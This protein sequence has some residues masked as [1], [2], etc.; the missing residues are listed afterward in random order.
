MNIKT[1]LV[2]TLLLGSLSTGAMAGGHHLTDEQVKKLVVDHYQLMIFGLD[3][4]DDFYKIRHHIKMEG[5]FDMGY[6]NL[7]AKLED[8]Y[9]FRAYGDHAALLD[10]MEDFDKNQ[11]ATILSD[12]ILLLKN[13]DFDLY[14]KMKDFGL[15][16]YIVSG[17]LTYDVDGLRVKDRNHIYQ[18]TEMLGINNEYGCQDTLSELYMSPLNPLEIKDKLDGDI[19]DSDVKK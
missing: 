11:L 8:E 15:F 14:N 5:N 10:R 18:I 17:D 2:S 16:D 7:M 19:C 6:V 1:I 12:H 3:H 9:G 13:G 4:P